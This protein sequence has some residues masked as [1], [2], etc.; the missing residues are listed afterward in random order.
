MILGGARFLSGL[1]AGFLGDAFTTRP[2][3]IFGSIVSALGVALCVFVKSIWVLHLTL[4]LIHGYFRDTLGAY[5]LLFVACGCVTI[6]ASSTWVVA[7]Y[8]RQ[9]TVKNKWTIDQTQTTT[10]I[11]VGT[12]SLIP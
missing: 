5:N 7:E 3:I 6:L 12:Y 9:K 8:A 10:N 2:L 1:L 11:L 4:G